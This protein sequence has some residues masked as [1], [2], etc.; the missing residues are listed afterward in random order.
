MKKRRFTDTVKRIM[1]WDIAI[2][3]LLFVTSN[4]FTISIINKILTDNLD[5][6]LK[7]E[8]GTLLGSFTIENDTI[9]VTAYSELK[10]PDFSTL[11]SDSYLL[12]IYNT[13]GKVIAMSEN[14]R[15]FDKIPLGFPNIKSKYAFE[16]IE[17][18]GHQLRTVYILLHEGS[19]HNAAFLQL[20]MFKTENSSIVKKII[21]FNLFN[22]PLILLIIILVSIFLA[23]KSYAPLDKIISIAEN[24]T[25]KNLNT[26]IDYKADPDDELGRL[27]D[28]LNSLFARLGEQLNHISQFTDNAS[29]QLMTPLTAVKTELEY[30]LKRER[31]VDEYKETLIALNSQTDKMIS[32]VKSLLIIAKF[33][34]AE[35]YK[36]VFKIEPIVSEKIK[37]LFK[38]KNIVYDVDKNIYLKGN[39]DGF[40]IILENLIDNAIKYSVQDEE[41]IVKIFE[42][43][44]LLNIIVEDKGIGIADSEKERIFER[45]YR[46]SNVKENIGGY[47]L[48]LCLVKTITL[49]MKGQISVEN[50][51][52]AGTKFI[53]TLPAIKIE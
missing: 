5:E 51:T 6:K 21:I 26:K 13:T 50:N 11:N 40:Q 7:N 1:L 14:I 15:T 47:G 18:K 20:S 19:N 41:V 34:G 9:R 38:N 28:T 8:I 31:S 36:D 52:P 12:Q 39:M 10:E 29:H 23:K 24:I 16:D 4:V 53:I 27:R 45:F 32:I 3:S 25:A 37:P 49:A 22:L 48:G 30:I 35:D 42:R 2:F 43:D 17:V 33:S 44:E 46:S